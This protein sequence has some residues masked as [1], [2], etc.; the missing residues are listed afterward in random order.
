MCTALSPCGRRRCYSPASACPAGASLAG[1]QPPGQPSAASPS[2]RFH[3]LRTGRG[4][5][6]AVGGCEDVCVGVDAEDLPSLSL[7][8]YFISR[9][10]SVVS[11]E[12][13][14]GLRGL[15]GDLRGAERLPHAPHEAGRGR[16]CPV[17]FPSSCWGAASWPSVSRCFQN[18][19]R[20]LDS[21]P[22][23]GCFFAFL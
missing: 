1:R 4:G 5:R 23:L 3:A 8:V 17:A 11:S 2:G 10:A 20:K 15:E 14:R 6:H 22:D 12:S 21:S 18:V 7:G 16:S 13:R 9:D 19:H